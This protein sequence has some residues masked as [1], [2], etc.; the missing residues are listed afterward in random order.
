M[1]QT[2]E[3]TGTSE[4]LAAMESFKRMTR[5][6]DVAEFAA[7]HKMSW[8]LLHPASTISWPTR[9]LDSAVYAC[10]GYR[11]YHFAHSDP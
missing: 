7:R 4:R 8:Y 1:L 5:A 9:V 2:R 10:D 6:E 11:V 3:E